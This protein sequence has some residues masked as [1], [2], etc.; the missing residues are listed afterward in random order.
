MKAYILMYSGMHNPE[1]EL[2]EE[3]NQTLKGLVAGLE[4]KYLGQSHS[5]LG[6][7][8]YREPNF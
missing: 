8:G 4:I 6:F 3:E 5:H 7:S 2:T 1:K